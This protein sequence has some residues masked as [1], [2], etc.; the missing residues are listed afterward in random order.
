VS[1]PIVETLERVVAFVPGEVV[2]GG[3]LERMLSVCA[4]LPHGWSS[5]YIESR[6]EAGNDQVDFLAAVGVGDRQEMHS[7]LQSR[8][9]QG[10]L[11]GSGWSGYAALCHDW[12]NSESIL[13]QQVPA[14]W[15][16][17][18]AIDSATANRPNFCVCVARDY[19][20]EGVLKADSAAGWRA[21]V[22]SLELLIPA[23]VDA[24]VLACLERTVADLA[25]GGR[26]IHLSVMLGRSSQI[27]LY[28]SIPAAQL[29]DHLKVLAPDGGGDEITRLARLVFP[30][31]DPIFLD[32]TISDRVAPRLGLAFSQLHLRGST[33]PEATPPWAALLDEL[34]R[35]GACAEGKRAALARWSG[36][37]KV[38][39]ADQ[40][41]PARLHRYLDIKLVSEPGQPLRAK[42]YLGF[43]PRATFV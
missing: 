19:L 40:K 8:L 7:S 2:P 31:L 1:W 37:Q 11:C 42:A 24:A 29:D 14:L 13:H 36:V 17:I 27:K 22:R 12:L 5:Y 25:P 20:R 38:V 34:V 41:W 18:D 32:L 16:E 10:R 33:V 30:L 43:Q 6:L 23:G 3:A 35:R 15:L 4:D 39:F 21:L 26:V 9:Q 28:V